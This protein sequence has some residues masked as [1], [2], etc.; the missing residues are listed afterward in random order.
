MGLC[1]KMNEQQARMIIKALDLYSRLL[2]GQVE[3]LEN[4]FRGFACLPSKDGLYGEMDLESI[5]GIVHALKKTIYPA[6][7]INGNPSIHNPNIH[8]QARVMVDLQRVLEYALHQHDS[9]LYQRSRSEPRRLST[10][11]EL[12]IVEGEE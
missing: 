10:E 12:A 7:P 4:L 5:R 8:D 2:M 9:K 1:L 3:E 6:L 11:C